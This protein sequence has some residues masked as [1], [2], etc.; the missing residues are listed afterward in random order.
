MW[1]QIELVFAQS[2]DRVWT[3]LV[4][5][6]PGV[7]AMLLV[8]AVSIAAAVAVRWFLKRSLARI[9]FDRRAHAWGITAGKDWQPAHAPSTLVARGVFWLLVLLGL[10]LALDVLGATTTSA[11]GLALIAFLPRIVVGGLIFLLGMIASRFLERSV[12]ITAV[13]MQLRDARLLSVGVKWVILVLATAVALQHVG[14]GGMLVTIAFSLVLGGI[15]LALAL[16][17]GLGSREVVSRALERRM[18]ERDKP[19]DPQERAI[20][21]L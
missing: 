18:Q 3:V 6:L 19:A 20:H 2:F 1:Q 12:L 13:N 11:L 4:S 10:A 8:L 9:G 17:V 21:H 5:V 16:A 15:V 14:I 7:L